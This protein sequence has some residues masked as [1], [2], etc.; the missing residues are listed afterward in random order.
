MNKAELIDALAVKLDGSKKQAAEAVE[1]VFDAIQNAVAAGEKVAITG[2]GVF[3]K[4][5]RAARTARNPR[6]GATVKVKATSV[7]KF[8]AGSEFKAVV[9]GKKKAAP[10]KKAVAKKAPA[11]KAVAKKAPVKKAAPVKRAAPAKKVVAK[12]APAKKA[13]AKKAPAKKAAA[14]R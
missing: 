12:R 3:E 8:R 6:T 2:F 9:A 4:A 14:R 5:N 13:P 7:P 11:K 10:A 1:A